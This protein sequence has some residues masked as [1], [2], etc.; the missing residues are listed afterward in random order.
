MGSEMCIRDRYHIEYSSDF[1]GG[2]TDYPTFSIAYLSVLHITLA[3]PGSSYMQTTR[4]ST[5]GNEVHPKRP[6]KRRRRCGYPKQRNEAMDSPTP[7]IEAEES[8]KRDQD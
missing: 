8:E 7:R 5:G 3:H 1:T 2:S 4:R 6:G